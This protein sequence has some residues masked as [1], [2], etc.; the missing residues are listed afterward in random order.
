MDKINGTA[1]G[2][3]PHENQIAG[4]RARLSAIGNETRENV[5]DKP[6]LWKIIVGVA[7]VVAALVFADG[8]RELGS[9]LLYYALLAAGAA[10]G[11]LGLA[12][13]MRAGKSS[14]SS[15]SATP[16]NLVH[17]TLLRTLA[18]LS[19]ADTNIKN[20][21]VETIAS[22]YED[23][24]GNAVTTAEIR[25]AARADLYEDGSFTKYLSGIEGEIER[26]GKRLIMDAMCTV[27]RADGSVSPLEVDFFNDVA[28]ALRVDAADLKDLTAE[29]ETKFAE[30]RD[31]E[32]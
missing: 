9:D 25:V 20:V 17:D 5:V 28:K 23:L 3:K 24:T 30:E 15:E 31:S 26:D 13:Y 22:L 6:G 2:I 4:N 32:T 7:L 27:V 21:E 10:L 29:C 12:E 11:G 18:R 8:V 1:K 14:A 19:S 16:E